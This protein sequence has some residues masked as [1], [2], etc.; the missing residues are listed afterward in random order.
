MAAAPENITPALLGSYSPSLSGYAPADFSDAE[1][2][3]PHEIALDPTGS[4]NTHPYST[5]VTNVLSRHMYEI[6]EKS[7]LQPVITLKWR[8]RMREFFFQRNDELIQVLKRPVAQHPTL[9][10]TE[11][12]IRKFGRAD[13]TPT[14]N[15]LNTTF[16]DLTGTTVLPEILEELNK[17]GPASVSQLIE[18]IKWVYETYRDTANKLYAKE[19]LL[20]DKIDALDIIYKKVVSF[21][22]MGD[23][24]ESLE[25]SEALQKL[26]KRKFEENNIEASYD[27]LILTYRRFAVLKD[28]ISSLRGMESVDKEPLCSICLN[29]PVGYVLNPCG[30]TF[31]GTCSKRQITQCY[32]CRVAVKDKLRIFF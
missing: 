13:F 27:D 14:H 11:H 15:S 6:K 7:L 32:M 22:S 20:K 3:R 29:E 16:L 18:E 2:T 21:M 1:D 10:Q 30:H 19:M 26:L 9:S 8:N 28:I 12:F 4:G 31:C 17:I 23:E 24:P 5:L 25:I